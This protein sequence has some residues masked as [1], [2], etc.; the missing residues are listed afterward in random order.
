MTAEVELT[1]CAN[2]PSVETRL[3]CNK[4]DKPICS[5]C[6]VLT[7][8]GYTCR[9]CI[10]GQQKV[11]DTTNWYDYPLVFVVVFGLSY[12]GSRV[13]LL[14]G[15]WMIF[16][17]PIAGGIIAEA[18]RLVSRKRRSKQLFLMAAIAAL[19]GCVPITWQLLRHFILLP[20]I[21]QIVYAVLMTSTFYYRLS[22]IKIR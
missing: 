20:F 17:A 4:C 19:A 22:G 12:L 13:T 18:A 14:L 7:P 3:R 9:E 2:H 10:K 5:K 1:Y 16:L 15:F 21:Y 6:A 11:F 8:T